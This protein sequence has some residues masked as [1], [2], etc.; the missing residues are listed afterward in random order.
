MPA[1]KTEWK[2]TVN[3]TGGAGVMTDKGKTW[4]TILSRY[5][6]VRQLHFNNSSVE[7]NW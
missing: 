1:F 7:V 3:E 2:S 5:R 6:I 4:N